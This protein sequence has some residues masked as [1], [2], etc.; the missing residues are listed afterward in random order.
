MFIAM[1]TPEKCG[2]KC[3][4]LSQVLHRNSLANIEDFSLAQYLGRLKGDW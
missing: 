4:K 2:G 1:D 3:H